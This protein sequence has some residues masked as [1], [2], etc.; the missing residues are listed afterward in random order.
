MG[1]VINFPMVCS[2]TDPVGN[3]VAIHDDSKERFLDA[4]HEFHM[5]AGA[6]PSVS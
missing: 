5:E 2:Y 6:V 3:V 4:L 1:D